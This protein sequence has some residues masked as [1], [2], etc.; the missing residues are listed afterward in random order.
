MN[1]E[2]KVTGTDARGAADQAAALLQEI[3]GREPARATQEAPDG[4]RKDLAAAAAIA[5]LIF[6]IPSAVLA[7]L[8]VKDRLDRRRLRDRVETTRARL[9]ET[10]SEATLTTP[11][12][13]SLDLRRA[14]TDE[15]VDLLL[16]EVGTED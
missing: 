2:I 1:L 11:R 16:R 6:S 7:T 10:D 8:E 5:S 3:T 4:P 9:A 13:R 12:G 14:S 15:V